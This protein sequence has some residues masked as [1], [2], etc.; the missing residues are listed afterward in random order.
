[1]Y[2]KYGHT[3]HVSDDEVVQCHVPLSPTIY[4]RDVTCKRFKMTL[5]VIGASMLM[6]ALALVLQ[7]F[8]SNDSALASG[9]R[10][11]FSRTPRLW[12]SLK[13]FIGTE[14]SKT[15]RNPPKLLIQVRYRLFHD[16]CLN[17]CN[18]SLRNRLFFRQHFFLDCKTVC[19]S[20]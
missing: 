12:S 16:R 13:L 19:W 15:G 6:L 2:Q 17:L 1:V 9:W 20:R 10:R 4:V 5:N 11:N 3:Q 18:S 7:H 8:S 14:T